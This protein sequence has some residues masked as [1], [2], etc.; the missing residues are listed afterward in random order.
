MQN[1]NKEMDP[2]NAPI[3][4]NVPLN[5]VILIHFA[6]EHAFKVLNILVEIIRMRIGLPTRVFN[7]R[8]R[9]TENSR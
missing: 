5:M 9:H 4:A 1:R 2:D 8:Y 3:F 6:G 7:I